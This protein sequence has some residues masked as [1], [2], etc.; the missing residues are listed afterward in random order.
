MFGYHY[1][2]D[3]PWYKSLNITKGGISYFPPDRAGGYITCEPIKGNYTNIIEIPPK[4]NL[5]EIDKEIKL[6]FVEYHRYNEGG[7][8]EFYTLD[9][10]NLLFRQ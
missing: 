4:Y 1:F 3:N 5:H 7:G 2:R 6:H 9:I 8:T 10:I